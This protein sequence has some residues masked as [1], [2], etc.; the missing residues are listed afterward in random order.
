MDGVA[1]F[2]PAGINFEMLCP[3][4]GGFAKH[5]DWIAQAQPREA[6]GRGHEVR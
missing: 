3:D 1:V 6:A 4:L 2:F 5:L